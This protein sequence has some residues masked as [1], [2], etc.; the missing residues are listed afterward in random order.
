[1][2]RKLFEKIP[3]NQKKLV[4]SLIQ[5]AAFMK[6]TLEDLQVQINENGAI[7]EYQNGANQGGRKISS[8]VQAYNA[9]LKNYHGVI[10]T[11]T[12]LLPAETVKSRLAALNDED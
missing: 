9:M 5:N 4:S 8:E 1:M 7:E 6:A 3:E 10:N 12:G 2:L 11:L